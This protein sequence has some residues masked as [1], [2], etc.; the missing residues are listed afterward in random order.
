MTS[1]ENGWRQFLLIWIGQ[2]VSL[3][4][5]ALT[6]FAMGVWA[7]QTTGLTTSYALLA[8]AA[9]APQVL[10][11]PLAGALVDR[12]DRRWMMILSDTGSALSTGVLVAFLFADSLQLWQAYLIAFVSASFNTAQLPAFTAA[13]TLLV[14]K[15][16]YARA[17]GLVEI[18]QAGA[19]IMAPLLAGFLL[20]RIGTA[21]V[22]AIDLSTFVI[23]VVTLL[24]VRVP[25]PETS[26]AGKEAAGSLLR[27]S[28]IGWTYLRQRP[29]LFGLMLYF[30]AFNLI[31]PMALVLTMPLVL[32][33]TDEDSL[34]LVM[35]LS[36]FGLLA[37]GI[38]MAAWG[39]PQ[40]KIVGVLGFGPLVTIGL[41]IAGLRPSVPLIILG[42]FLAY[43]AVPILSG[44]SQAI[45]QSK[46]EP[47][48]QGRVFAFR[49]LIAKLT[50]PIGF[51]IAG[52]LA[53]NVFRPLLLEG[54]PLAASVGQ[55]M[56]TGEGRG[57]GLLLIVMSLVFLLCTLLTYA[58]SPVRNVETE[59]PDAMPEDSGDA[60]QEEGV[61]GSEEAAAEHQ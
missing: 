13:T 44:C 22:V 31:V 23:A 17:S 2:V 19:Q 20:L 27:E 3:F 58:Y 18:G 10:F 11:A 59:L 41:L 43:L 50:G 47:D 25:K 5:S 30:A 52:P 49:G 61:A 29:G 35:G 24:M 40:K 45:W 28:F 34:G 33:F 38:T 1:Q 42:L 21:G 14:P 16:D 54:G 60:P 6:G 55:I 4:G 51:L 36:S 26:E 57:V 7:F 48:L 9:T 56:G 12:Y 46:V 37:G 8:V 39:G 53:D 32:G 15:K